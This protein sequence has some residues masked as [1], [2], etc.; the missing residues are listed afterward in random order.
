MG[1]SRSFP[2]LP[3]PLYYYALL[4]VLTA[5]N[6]IYA[7]PLPYYEYGTDIELFF[8]ATVHT[9]DFDKKISSPE[10]ESK[11]IKSITA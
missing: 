5:V 6:F 10:R 11:W 9:E 2:S 3:P 1:A 4:V 8:T 7:V